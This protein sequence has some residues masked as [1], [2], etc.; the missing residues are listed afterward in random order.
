MRVRIV[1]RAYARASSSLAIYVV[2]LVIAPASAHASAPVPV[3]LAPPETTPVAEDS[4]NDPLATPPAASDEVD[5]EPKATEVTT[6]PTAYEEGSPAARYP[7]ATET[8]EDSSATEQ[9]EGTALQ[10]QDPLPEGVPERL[11]PLQI[12]GWWSTF[13]GVSLA[14]AG[15]I[16][17][18]LAE[19]EQAQ[20]ELLSTSFN[21]DAGSRLLYE[22]VQ[23]DYERHLQRGNAFAWTSR[24]FLIVG[25]LTVVSGIVLFALHKKRSTPS[26]SA[27]L[28]W[29]GSAAMEVTF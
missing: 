29:R 23:S 10:T 8:T 12:A 24:G 5:D 1:P 25:G 9:L 28:R 2:A 7:T 11:P 17:A 26:T 19:R 21:V 3:E 14:T 6:S 13:A 27:R 18:G 15:G 22:D 20:A 16:F 4:E